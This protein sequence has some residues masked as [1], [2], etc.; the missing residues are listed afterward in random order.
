MS[1][2]AFNN[3]NGIFFNTLRKKVD[4]Y[5]TSNNIKTTGNYKLYLKTLVMLSSAAISYIVL[6]FFTPSVW[7][8]LAICALFG[9]ILA[10]I[11]F[12]VMHDG[13][14]GSYSSKKWL[15][16]MMSY[17]LNLM[18]GSAY[19]WK[20]KHNINHHSYTNIHGMDDDIDIE[21]WIRTN[22]NQPRYWYHRFQHIYWVILYGTTYVFWIFFQDFKKYF[23]GKIADTKFRKMDLKG[24]V[25]FWGSKIMYVLF[26]MIIPIYKVG[27]IDTILGYSVI[28]FVCGLFISVV[29]QLAH[30][31]KDTQ[32]PVSSEK[33]T[34]IDQEWA[35]HQLL[36]TAN[37]S[38]RSKIISWFTGGLNYQ[39]EHHLFPKISHVHYPKISE[40]V[41]ETCQQFNVN[42]IEYPTMLAAVRSHVAYLRRIGKNDL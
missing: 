26:F 17:S 39:I 31:I 23:S 3:N 18:G 22:Q 15:N 33:S 42:Y 37:F 41:K 13:G 29:F 19:I 6:V 32:F 20:I 34:R 11:G 27:L 2:V 8:S 38:T 16:E 4:H 40:L 25:V 5:F 9:M 24:H 35:V 7:L 14:H 28:A 36:T 21:P 12:N 30:V 1:K 10:G